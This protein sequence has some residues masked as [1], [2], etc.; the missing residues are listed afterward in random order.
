[1]QFPEKSGTFLILRGG[2]EMHWTFKGTRQPEI[3]ILVGIL[4]VLFLSPVSVFAQRTRL[5]PGFNIFSPAQ[6]VELGQQNSREA[7]KQLPMLNR[8]MVD[9]YLDRLGKR[10]ARYAPG[11]KYPY[12]FKCVN[13]ATINA[14]ALP[15]GFLYVNRGLIEAADNE[16]ELAGV[17]GHEIGHVALRHGTNQASKAQPAQA[18]LAVLSGALG[19]KSTGAL[20]AQLGSSFAVNSILLKYSRDDERQSDLIG[21]Q[22]LYDAGYQPRQMATFFE[23]LEKGGSGNRGLAFFSSHPNPENRIVKINDEISKLGPLDNN[24]NVDSNEFQRIK[25]YL[26]SLPPPPK[27]AAE[28]AQSSSS[29]PDSPKTVRP[30]RPSSRLN[31][32]DSGYV[33]LRHPDN[34][35]VYGSDREFTLAPDNGFVRTRGDS[36]ALAYGMM[37]A[38]STSVSGDSLKTATDQLISNLRGSNSNMRVS[39]DQGQI[40][41]GGKKAISKLLL[42]DSPIGGREIDWLVTVMRPEG[43]VHF[44]F[45]APEAEFPDYQSAFQK[46]LNSVRF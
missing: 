40:K 43:L 3:G 13:D 10:L 17:I 27:V 38:V 11:E 5:K 41:V 14:F 42:N 32:Y 20:I 33:S 22:I 34:W 44:I 24:T 7:E 21:A 31:T 28:S 6:D 9:D 39:K 1:V 18:L 46:V 19:N 8:P 37:M 16:A 2:Q 45:V 15:G 23:K 26:K 30:P 25:K 12:Q 36:S 4:L 29:T 35:K